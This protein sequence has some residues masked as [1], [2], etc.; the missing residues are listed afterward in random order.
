MA[1]IPGA[2]N[3]IPGVFTDVITQSRGISLPGGSRI[4]AMIGE[5]STDETIVSQALGGGKD[6]LNSTYSGT[7]G[8]D[9]R[10]FQLSN[11][12]LVSN[13]TT[14]FKNGIP[15]TGLESL[16]DS[17][18]FNFKY[19]YRVDITTGQVELQRAHL[20]DQGGADFAPLSTNVGQGSLSSLTLVDS[21][22]PPEIWT[23]RCVKVQRDSLN[24]PIVNTATFLA[25]G[26][27]SGSKLDANG[28]PIVWIANQAGVVSN[29]VLSFSVTETTP[30]FREGDAFIVQVASGVLVR[31]DSL[32]ANY[33]PTLALNDPELLNGL[34]PVA[35]KHGFPSLTNNLSLGAQ[36]AFANQAP[37]LMT[38]QSAPPLP[39][40]TS[41]ILDQ[42]VNSLSLDPDEFIFPL[43]PGVVPDFNSNIHFFVK[44]NATN[45]E[46]QIL[47]NKLDYYL[48]DDVGQPTTNAFIFDDTPAPGGFSYFYT[49]KES[50]ES[51]NFGEDGY[52][53]RNLAFYNQGVFS[54]SGITFDASYVGKALKILESTNSGN[55]GLF[56]ITAVTGGKLYVVADA[57]TFPPSSLNANPT[58]LSDFITVGTPTSGFQII[59]PVTG[60]QVGAN[61]AT[62][63]YVITVGATTGS[64]YLKSASINTNSI[65]S[66]LSYRVKINSGATPTASQPVGN[67]GLYDI[68]A[69]PTF[70]VLSTTGAGVQAV[71]TTT[72][73]H[74][75]TSGDT[76]TITGVVGNTA[77]NG[78]FQ[79]TVVDADE[80]QLDGVL[81]NGAYVSGGTVSPH[82]LTIKKALVNES[83]LEYQ[84]LDPAD[85][86]NF[87]VVNH[88]VVP[89]GYALR[90]TIV[91]SRDADFYD[92]G[93]INALESLERVECDILVPL[94]KQT[95]SVIF[96][97]CLSHCL[98]M[99]NI[100]NKKERVLFIGAINGLTPD[101]LTGVDP[102]A[103]EDI[104][105]LEG[106]QGETVTD[107]LAGNVE[108]L[109]NY[110]VADAFGNTYR[111]VYF[112]PDQIVVQAG[113]D[114]VLIDGF[115]LAAAAAGYESADVRLEN[116]LTNKT[117]SGFTI[118]RNKQFSPSVLE[119][120]AGAGV[121]TL[122]P[123]AGGGRVVWGKTTTQS[124]FPEEQEISIVFIRDRIAKL[125][126]AT[127]QG[128]IGTPETENTAI[129][130]NTQGTLIMNSLIS[131]G[132]ITAY[133]DLSVVRDS[134]DPTQWNVSVRVQPTYPINFIYIKVSVGQL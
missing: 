134:V 5:G 124:G 32:T 47:P 107:I 77:A 19:D 2:N 34:G 126:R 29:G 121:T 92:A 132:L 9:G 41:Y 25:F 97:N 78:T 64:A 84:I 53:G 33:I 73:P 17:N 87:V 44:N 22:A 83:N 123:V 37:A 108:D 118:L 38:V 43:P 93:W 131:Q 1:N 31:N 100:R 36:L 30:A 98:V 66:I 26:E 88:N 68:T 117:L 24:V 49:V 18:P 74:G 103:V 130:L 42:D 71:V 12:P 6:G 75:L 125:L 40:R 99:S 106:I 70:S 8:A 11:F 21:N 102:A 65:A 55:Y 7:S 89:N 69:A 82:K 20:Q 119:A 127:F 62:D 52:I 67:N 85:M 13:R 116:P 86:S 57:S 105:I 109:A 104:G 50:V 51:I 48:L 122:Q 58:Y 115:Y 59:D 16:I 27:I 112:Y 120:L 110:S 101:N 4:A 54:V 96:Q 14:L 79:I 60:L 81:G 56:H 91:D 28:N 76:V 63:G 129:I 23:I 3:V 61:A 72:T 128:F 39:R 114:N 10:H 45:V 133:R 90:V 113:S 80:F 35:A 95:I 111:C 15:L 46:T 94:P